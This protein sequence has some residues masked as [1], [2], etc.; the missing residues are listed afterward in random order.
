VNETAY[1]YQP[2]KSGSILYRLNVRFDN[3]EQRFSNVISLKAVNVL[4][5]PRLL[6][7]SIQ[8][9]QLKVSSA[10]GYTYI[11]SDLSGRILLK[12]A[13]TSGLSW[14]D[15]QALQKGAY[16]IRFTDGQMYAV[17]KFIKQ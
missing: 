11:I 15:I 5:R 8:G 4:A 13:G 9:D 16:L 12:G 7:T 1:Q 10:I 17:E 2:N 14:I 6:S 3:G